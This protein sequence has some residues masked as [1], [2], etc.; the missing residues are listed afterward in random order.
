MRC[1]PQHEVEVWLVRLEEVRRIT[2][3]PDE[4][5][6]AERFHFD[7]DRERW[8]RARSAL[9]QILAHAT[10]KA[11]EAVR[12]LVSEHGKPTMESAGGI[13]FNLSHA[14]DYA[15]IAVSRGIP[16]G[17]DIER[18]RGNVDIARL[19]HRLGESAEPAGEKELFQRWTRRE[20]RTK[21]TGSPLFE[22]PRDE[23]IAIDIDAPDGYAASVA[24]KSSTPVPVMRYD[25]PHGQ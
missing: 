24:L 14:G 11:P 20:A 12:F 1:F 4:Q 8:S 19:L 16:V 22:T 25:I 13:E 5:Q 15:A 18:I 2:L 7:R 10:G 17:V 23:V 6:R 3:L 9:R 21:A